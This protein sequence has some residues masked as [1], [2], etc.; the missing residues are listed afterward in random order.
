MAAFS[1]PFSSASQASGFVLSAAPAG[2]DRSVSGLA[3]ASRRT[4]TYTLSPRL[5]TSRS[6]SSTSGNVYV[7]AGVSVAGLV[8]VDAANRSQRKVHRRRR[9]PRNVYTPIA[10]RSAVARAARGGEED[11]P[12]LNLRNSKQLRNELEAA[13]KDNQ[14]LD[15]MMQ[16]LRGQNLN[17]QDRQ[18]E[19]LE[20]Q[21]VEL[22]SGWVD[23]ETGLPLK[24]K[25]DEIAEYFGQR[26]WTI[27]G[28]IFQIASTGGGL[29]LSTTLDKLMGP[30]AGSKEAAEL[31]VRRA[32]EFRRVVTQLGPLFIKLGQALSIRPDL[33]SPRAMVE[34]QALCD[35]VPSYENKIAMDT[36]ESDLSKQLGRS[37]KVHDVFETITPAPVAAASLGQVYKATLRDNGEEVAVKVQ[38]PGVLATA[39]MDLFL[40][41][42]FGKM[43]NYLSEI[44]LRDSRRTDPVALLDEFAFRLYEE[45]DYRIECAYG[46]EVAKHMASLPRVVVP[47]NFPKYCTRKV[48]VA[49]WVE[50]EKLSQSQANDVREL[51]NVGVQAYLTQLLQ[52]GLFHADPHPGNM[53]R[54]PDGRLAI[55]DFGLMTQITDDQKFGLVEAIAHLVHRDYSAIGNDFKQLDF[56]PREVD[57]QPIVPALS[58]VFDVAL[59]GGGAKSINFQELAADLAEITFEYPFKIP[60]Y[61]ALIIRAIGVLEG[62]A[63]VGDPDFAIVDESFP[64]LSKRLMV[65]PPERLRQTLRYMVYGKDGVFDA[66][67]LIDLLRAFQAFRAIE[68]DPELLRVQGDHQESHKQ[69]SSQPKGLVQDTART[70]TKL[71]RSQMKERLVGDRPTSWA[72]TTSSSSQ[73]ATDALKFLFSSEGDYVRAFLL[74]EA[75]GSI[76]SLGRS[77]IAALARELP[78][79]NVGGPL[80]GPLSILSGIVAPPLTDK[81]ERALEN[82][83]RLFAF[84]ADDAGEAETATPAATRVASA[85]RA[86][87]ADREL[88]ASVSAFGTELVRAVAVRVSVRVLRGTADTLN[89]VVRESSPV[90]AAAR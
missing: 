77:G 48:H 67:R 86:V 84:F 47:K 29:L 13:R 72:R 82:V 25:P 23:D 78:G 63:L 20:M 43:I 17:Q 35:K 11:S 10:V 81:E 51:V 1:S 80:R 44:G 70:E 14:E 88:A 16:G 7:V 24:Y 22:E 42:T 5:E 37:V 54:T 50:G 21:L 57:A 33:L 58:R 39:S 41:R 8:A 60:P 32:K 27:A 18:E 19:G 87:T 46:L 4:N 40:L 76:D 6:T 12:G 34:L 68:R 71:R 73:T 30:A 90:A 26:P 83:R 55:L 28:R 64:W 15:L 89:S 49:E 69:E 65:N 61:F 56:I 3:P 79:L 59:S 9:Q 74:E 75:A 45:L 38:R 31:D 66:E 52:T 62:I 36:L 53:L 2:D 85:L